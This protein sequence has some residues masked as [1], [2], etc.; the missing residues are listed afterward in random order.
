MWATP[1]GAARARS[2]PHGP[3]QQGSVENHARARLVQR[4]PRALDSAVGEIAARTG[5][6]Q[7]ALSTA[8]ARLEEADQTTVDPHDRRALSD[9]RGRQGVTTGRRS[10]G[11]TRERRGS[12]GTGRRRPGRR[13]PGAR[14]WPVTCGRASPA[15]SSDLAYALFHGRCCRPESGV[16]RPAA[17]K[18]ANA[19]RLRAQSCSRCDCIARCA[20]ATVSGRI[21]RS[22]VH[23]SGQSTG[24][25]EQRLRTGLRAEPG[26]R[27]RLIGHTH[28]TPTTA[29]TPPP[30]TARMLCTICHASTAA[31]LSQRSGCPCRSG[32]APGSQGRRAL[33]RGS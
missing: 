14:R 9:P 6:P 19:A 31:R 21:G 17:T 4:H 32:V 25:N 11:D 13:G 28:A 5:L 18:A 10:A 2:T 33:L 1:R 3:P 20:S 15:P 26:W 23:A 22:Q 12:G 27:A 29:H 16:M 30:N 8:V 24:R 7:S